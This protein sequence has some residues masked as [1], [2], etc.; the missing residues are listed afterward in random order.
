MFK[1]LERRAL[2]LV[3]A[4]T[5]VLSGVGGLIAAAEEAIATPIAA[6]E[7]GALSGTLPGNRDSGSFALYDIDYAGGELLTVRVTPVYHD[8][9][10][11]AAFGA[12]LYRPDGSALRHMTRADGAYLELLHTGD[13]AT[14]T[15]QVHNFSNDAVSFDVTVDGATAVT[16]VVAEVATEE[17]AVAEP[18]VEEVV[19]EQV[20]VEE[21]VVEE[22]IA[23]DETEAA[24][25]P[26]GILSTGVLVGVGGGAFEEVTVTTADDEALTLELQTVPLDPAFGPAAGFV[27]YGDNGHRVAQGVSDGA[28]VFRATFRGVSDEAFLV[29]VYNYAAGQPLAYTLRIVQ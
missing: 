13:A 8:A 18:V 22:A 10:Q 27:I 14:L 25:L 24:D 4:V 17:A 20:A 21:P 3:L 28:G 7:T 29:Q 15:L 6:V 26:A 11:G 9:S 5:L 23:A 19:V 12:K 1:S 16:P 2:S